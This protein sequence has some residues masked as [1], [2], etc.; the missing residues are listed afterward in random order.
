[1]AATA[2]GN[3]FVPGKGTLVT[4]VLVSMLNVMGGAAVAP[5][6][7]A[8]SE[9]FPDASEALVSLVITLPSL[10]VAISGFFV[11]VVADRVGKARTLVASLVLFTVAGLSGALTTSLEAL[12]ACRFVLGVGIAG[13]STASG[14]LITEYYED[15]IRTKVFGWQSAAAGISVLAL[16]PAG[17]FLALAGWHMPFLVY[18]VGLVLLVFVALFIREAAGDDSAMQIAQPEE[19]SARAERGGDGLSKSANAA[20]KL[21]AICLVAAF[22]PQVMSFLVPTKMPYLVAALGENSAVTGMLLGGF[23]VA[24]FVGPLTSAPIQRRFRRSSIIAGCFVAVAIGCGLLAFAPTIWIILGGALFIGMGVGCLMPLLMNLVAQK[25]TR[26]NSGKRMGAMSMM[27]N[28]GQFSSTLLAGGVMA[29]FGTHQA[30]F[31]AGIVIGLAV[32]VAA[33]ALRSTID[34]D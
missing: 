13:I 6:L 4:L 19:G 31:C 23:G 20:A 18:S 7:P 21:F 17:G 24:N 11:G 14:A 26:S 10:A 2:K 32:A 22:V 15:D 12:L 34:A 29:L 30:V 25:S 33:I 1:M 5:A 16:E 3:A 27:V 8:I 28:L 9:A